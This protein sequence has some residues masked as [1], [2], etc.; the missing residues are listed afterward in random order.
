MSSR[1]FLNILSDLEKISEKMSMIGG[2][3][4]LSYSADTQSD[5][6]TTLLTKISRLGSEISNRILFFDL[7]WKTGM[8]L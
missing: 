1:Q 8:N 2:Y 4:S 3:A 6:T 5:E 7:W